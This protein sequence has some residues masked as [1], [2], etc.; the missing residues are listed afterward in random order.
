MN[1]TTVKVLLFFFSIL[2]I[3]TIISQSYI[4]FSN[5]YESTNVFE[6][7]AV[8]KISFK[9]IFVRDETPVSYD[10]S[11]VVRYLYNDGSKVM[12]NAILANVYNS[13]FDIESSQK[14]QEISDEVELLNKVQNKGTT[15]V[16]QPEFISN[17]INE[18][19]R[20]I[21]KYNDEGNFE[22]VSSE[23]QELLKLLDI[24]QIV[25]GKE[26]D[27][28]SRISYL[29]NEIKNYDS[30]KVTPINTVSTEKEGY[31]VSYTDG[32]ENV[33]NTENIDSLDVN[34][35]ENIINN[36][37]NEQVDNKYIGK[38]IDS[39]SCK[40]VGIVD[41]GENTIKENT[42]VKISIDGSDI[43]VKATIDEIKKTDDAGKR[44]II[45]S[46]D[47]MTYDKVKTRIGEI[48]LLLNKYTGIK[49]PSQA[50][51]F[52]NG[53]KGVYITLG[54]NISFRK[55]VVLYE[56]DD[57][58]IVEE[59][60]DSSYLQPYDEVIVEGIKSLQGDTQQFITGG[61]ETNGK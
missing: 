18:K 24:M 11:G 33:V 20:S 19:Y 55:I 30:R 28:N 47:E 25:T 51:R 1:T 41:N 15:E 21:A 48:D 36:P 27:Y 12:V 42:T 5:R 9:G 17:L 23:K 39:Y 45:M 54:E 7:T 29:E 53:E 35:I 58:V 44:I 60:G 56:S 16:A 34:E 10:G 61:S 32:Y 50:I 3:I 37:V 40:I 49:V 31:F 43:P 8:N 52:I 57:Y 38:I 4:S 46:C 13:E 22:K 26:T 2:L 6:E 14:I 59:N